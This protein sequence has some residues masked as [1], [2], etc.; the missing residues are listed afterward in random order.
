MIEPGGNRVE[1]FGDA[2]YLIFDPTWKPVTWTQSQVEKGIIWIGSNL[3]QDFFVYG[4]PILEAA[5]TEM[6]SPAKEAETV[7]A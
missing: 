3:P 2:G 4:T 7:P 1:L 5:K 6:P